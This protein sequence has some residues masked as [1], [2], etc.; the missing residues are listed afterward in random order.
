MSRAINTFLFFF[1]SMSAFSPLFSNL[2]EAEKEKLRKQNV[3]GEYIQRTED[4]ISYSLENPDP[5]D[6][7]KYPWENN[8]APLAT[9][10]T[11]DFFRCRGSQK[12]APIIQGLLERVDCGGPEN[13]SLPLKN[14]KE[15]IYPV[16]IDLLN[17]IQEKTGKKVWVT[18]GHRCPVH[19][20]YAD[21]SFLSRTSKHMIGAEVDF[22][23]RGLEWTPERIV[24][25]IQQFY[26]DDARSQGKK[27]YQEFLRR[28]KPDRDVTTPSWYNQ[29]VIV[30]VYKQNEGRDFDN[31]HH[32][33]YISIQ[34]VY[35]REA[36]ERVIYTWPK[37]FNGY[38]RY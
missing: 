17:Y 22:F 15:F 31:Q 11:P 37:A 29:E 12:N 20:A 6:R 35:D 10:I 38:L 30:K 1:L 24:N 33:P 25:V 14:G 21:D 26:K 18:C 32:F 8:E 27:E 2:E 36:K 7:E 16:L 5:K 3:S 19:N 34:V 23:V 28:E 13:H 9:P 4:E